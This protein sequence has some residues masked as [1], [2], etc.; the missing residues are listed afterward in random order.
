MSARSV[1]AGLA[2]TMLS[3]TPSPG[4]A[5]SIRKEIAVAARPADVWAAVRDFGAVDKRLAPG[6]V[7]AVRLDGNVR[8]VTFANGTV[9]R[10]LLVSLDDDARRLVYAVVGGRL[11]THS[12]SVQVLADG[13][14]G[15][16]IIWISDFLPDQLTSYIDAQMNA[17]ARVM[18]ET[19]EHAAAK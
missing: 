9:A 18:K 15:S 13:D 2:A 17:A 12:A 7:V 4:D 5:A 19:L 3:V 11:T 10:E 8:E 16:R 6:F 1:F 14:S